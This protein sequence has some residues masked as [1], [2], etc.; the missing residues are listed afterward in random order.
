M[1]NEMSIVTVNTVIRIKQ[2]QCS[3]YQTKSNKVLL[4]KDYLQYAGY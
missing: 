1:P 4:M 3:K 2:T